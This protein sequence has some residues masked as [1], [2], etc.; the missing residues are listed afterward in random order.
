MREKFEERTASSYSD[1]HLLKA[2]GSLL[3][4]VPKSS[5]QI[6]GRLRQSIVGHIQHCLSRTMNGGFCA[7]SDA[8]HAQ[9]ECGQHAMYSVCGTLPTYLKEL[10]HLRRPHL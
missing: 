10:F 1:L 9:T 6:L 3:L 8:I 2:S 4:I 5:I 7:D